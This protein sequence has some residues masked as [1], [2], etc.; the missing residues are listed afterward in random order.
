MPKF[1]IRVDWVLFIA[2]LFLSIIGILM[3]YSTSIGETSADYTFVLRQA[4]FLIFGIIIY[5]IITNIDFRLI[6]QFS[7]LFY[8]IVILLLI[9]TPLVG[10]SVRGSTRWIDLGTI[11]IQAS[12]IA[13]PVL[14]L[15]LASF[16]ARYP[17]TKI[18]NVLISFIIMLVPAVLVFFQPDLGNT[19]II[20]SLWL[21]LVFAAG[22]RI[23]VMISISLLSAVILPFMW[24]ALKDY[25]QERLL[26]FLSSE[27]DLQGSN[28]NLV[29]S[30]IAVGSGGLFGKG[31]GRGT[32]SHLNFLPEQRTDF[33]F[34]ATAEELG[35][36]G[37][38]LIIGA[39]AIVIY[40]I[41]LIL[42]GS[43]DLLGS[44]IAVGVAS[45]I[46]IHVFI[47]IGMNIGIFPVT[48]I[49]LPLLSFGGSSLISTM[50]SLGLVNSVLAYRK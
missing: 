10:D 32:Q 39:F 22:I 34:A 29:Q 30:I 44:Y 35:F 28:Y 45:V 46:V 8:T 6:S 50:V 18:K 36:V 3:I 42:K 21:V 37:V 27:K 48:G 11:T 43:V 4:T 12:E 7:F 20:F 26:S 17:A 15:T 49:T 31:L 38:S 41:T 5:L 47:N 13:K 33:I 23:Y 2:T 25:Q 16:F 24:A 14:I 1:L 40:R 19:V 9:I